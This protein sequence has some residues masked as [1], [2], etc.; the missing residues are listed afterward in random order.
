MVATCSEG[1]LRSYEVI[2]IK[3]QTSS[4][5]WPSHKPR[6]SE[7]L[8]VQKNSFSTRSD[9]P[10]AISMA[11]LVIIA[12][13]LRIYVSVFWPNI[14]HPDEIFQTLEPAH[15]LAY[16]YGIVT[17]EWRRGAR[18][19]VVPSFLALAMRTTG[20][21]SKGST[22]YLI[23]IDAFL[24]TLSLSSVWFAFMWAKRASGTMTAVIAAFASSVCFELVYFSSKALTEVIATSFLLPGLY[25]GVYGS[26]TREKS[27]LFLAALFCSISISLRLQLAPAAIVAVAYFCYPEWRRRL[28][29]VIAGFSLPILAVGIVDAITWGYPWHS[30]ID[31]VR[32]NIIDNRSLNYGTQPW[33]WYLLMLFPLLGPAVL[34]TSQGAE[35]S[36]FLALICLVILG[37][38]C[39]IAH[40]EI[41][42][43]YP[44]FPLAIT[45]S[46]IGAVEAIPRGL[47]IVGLPNTPRAVITVALSFFLASSLC[48]LSVFANRFRAPGAVL[49]FDTLSREDHLCGVMLYRVDWW[50]TGG[51]A[52]L[53]RNVPTIL[54]WDK[55]RLSQELNSANAV[56]M[57]SL[58]ERLPSPFTIKKCWNGVCL[59]Q[60]PGVCAKPAIEDT[61]NEILKAT[62]N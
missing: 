48:S 23:S 26:N 27:R 62:G 40:K 37:S 29:S 57:P 19:W 15:R 54:I 2:V 8:I 3:G 59:W 14:F 21:L 51:Y 10:I 58:E 12:L 24:A 42:F 55:N 46:A 9:V 6:Q 20:W 47:T 39:V 49:A 43:L 31:Y 22:G 56:V 34:F 32:A 45:L 5:S 41:R 38:H 30:F 4:S 28:P 60:R 16:G 11:V 36:S 35:R 33:Y 25:L 44:L 52:H 50:Q 61:L 17:W 18:S 1:S 7:L 13:S 53:H